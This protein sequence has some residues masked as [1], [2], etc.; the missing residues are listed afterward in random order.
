MIS[1]LALIFGLSVAFAEAPESPRQESM[2]KI[3][4]SVTGSAGL[5]LMPEGDPG[6]P[7]PEDLTSRFFRTEAFKYFPSGAPGEQNENCRWGERFPRAASGF[8]EFKERVRAFSDECGD[9]FQAGARDLIRNVYYS[10]MARL[11]VQAHPYARHV[12]FDL[13]GGVRLKGLLA[14]HDDRPRPLVILRLGIFSNSEEMLA[15]RFLFMQLFEQ[16]PFNMLVLESMTG[17][18]YV[19]RN[20]ARAFAGLD[21]SVQ[22]LQVIRR[23]RDPRGKF[24][25]L[26]T[27][28]HL[29]GISM[30][31]HGQL[32]THR[33]QALQEGGPWVKSTLL[34]C[35]LMNI[36]TTLDHHFS[37]PLSQRMLNAWA[38][39]RF[40]FLLGTDP[41]LTKEK[42]LSDLLSLVTADYHGPLSDEPWIRWPDRLARARNDFW[43]GNDYWTG[44]KDVP[45]PL[46]IV[47][48]RNDQVVPYEL[49][50]GLL[51]T[52]ALDLGKTPWIL[53]PL[54][55][56]FHCSLPASYDWTQMSSLFQ[57]YLATFSP[58]LRLEEDAAEFELPDRIRSVLEGKEFA[59]RLQI[60]IAPGD[61][62][63]KITVHF[64]TRGAP[65][66]RRIWD[67]AFAPRLTYGIRLNRFDFLRERPV[68]T[69]AEIDLYTRWIYQNVK[70]ERKDGNRLR[71][72]WKKL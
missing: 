32:L 28:V 24:A 49:N 15:E 35:P 72:S 68:R 12:M 43:S 6:L 66:W 7:P 14:L 55:Q 2:R 65:W 52:G 47:A 46:F 20:Q 51:E 57:S 38:L 62:E 58:G 70:V 33:L 40:P 22:T 39:G 34:F 64:R 45:T 23:L 8:A 61:E 25:R 31:G 21:E 44:Y 13:P 63:A 59:P 69:V 56:G 1:L 11:E 54:D 50:A 16:A 10:M 37:S 48:T 36:R 71:F 29:A 9:E 4:E 53:L 17:V 3:F 42:F 18:E 27:D 5:E 19:R 26:M 30:G 67:R 60:S 41:R